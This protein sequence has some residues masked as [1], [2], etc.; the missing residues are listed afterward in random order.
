MEIIQKLFTVLIFS[1]MF[2]FQ[3]NLNLNKS[4]EDEVIK[5]IKDK[6]NTEFCGV[7]ELLHQDKMKKLYFSVSP[8]QNKK[9]CFKPTMS[10]ENDNRD[11]R[12]L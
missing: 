6:K 11:I 12:T 4:K 1:L 8:Q 10:N 9:S 7:Y 3:L 5:A 2:Y